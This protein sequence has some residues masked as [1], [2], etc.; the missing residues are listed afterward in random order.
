MTPSIEIPG[1]RQA[2]SP[3]GK[4][5]GLGKDQ[6]AHDTTAE[7]NTFSGMMA[8]LR[9]G[10]PAAPTTEGVDAKHSDGG[11]ATE[12]FDM[13]FTGSF[14]MLNLQA[15]RSSKVPSS[16]LPDQGAELT[17]LDGEAP[18]EVGDATDP[19]LRQSSDIVSISMQVPGLT[20]TSD[21]ATLP[22]ANDQAMLTDAANAAESQALQA[23][24]GVPATAPQTTPAQATTLARRTAGAEPAATAT[25]LGPAGQP[26]G[27]PAKAKAQRDSTSAGVNSSEATKDQG[28]T[29]TN[30][31]SFSLG[32]GSENRAAAAP[33]EDQAIAIKIQNLDAES[34]T[35][36]MP[37]TLPDAPQPS[38]TQAQAFGT[39]MTNA[40]PTDVPASVDAP[41]QITDPVVISTTDPNWEVEFVDSIVAQVSGENAVIDLALTP[42]NL[43]KVEVR[44]ELRD[45]RADVSFVTETREAA[46]LFTQSEGRLSDLMQRHGLDLAGQDSSHREAP[47][48][49]SGNTR[50]QQSVE[51]EPIV[52]TRQAPEGRVNLVA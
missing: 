23:A 6:S 3:Q 2:H 44:I 15:D 21:T 1:L 29:Q 14:N 10:K 25:A 52:P 18:T 49:P 13:T 39:M 50:S 28:T 8:A 43:G 47:S 51:G 12:E 37:K 31:P 45:G 16:T 26:A 32:T 17:T 5:S 48:R 7:R 34:D 42:E 38:A 33:R 30:S 4:L 22:L 19:V 9:N 24:L 40:A 36:A 27:G 46:R 35:T 41:Q 20:A 11:D